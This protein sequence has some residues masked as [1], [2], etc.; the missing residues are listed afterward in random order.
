[1]VAHLGDGKRLFTNGI[2]PD[3]STTGD[4]RDAVHYAQIVC[5]GPQRMGCA[6]ASN[7]RAA[8]LVC[9]YDPHGNVVGDRAYCG[10]GGR[11]PAGLLRVAAARAPSLPA[12]GRPG[13]RPSADTARR[14]HTAPPAP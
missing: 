11:S 3:F 7:A 4:Y 12:A 13:P 14:G 10:F 8:V 2:T 5:R 1:M 9:R 6:L